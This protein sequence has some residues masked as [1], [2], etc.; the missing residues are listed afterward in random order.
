MDENP[1]QPPVT[2][3]PPRKSRVGSQMTLL[4]MIGWSV[5]IAV[6]AFVGLVLIGVVAIVFGY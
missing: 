2:N 4:Q 3:P 1:Y 5:G 6:A